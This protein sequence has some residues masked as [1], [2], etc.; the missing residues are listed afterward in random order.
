MQQLMQAESMQAVHFQ[1]RDFM[2]ACVQCSRESCSSWKVTS[3]FFF[4][5]WKLNWKWCL[6]K[7]FCCWKVIVTFKGR[8]EELKTVTFLWLR[9]WVF[10]FWQYSTSSR[11]LISSEKLEMQFVGWEW[12]QDSSYRPVLRGILHSSLMQSKQQNFPTYC[13]CTEFTWT[14]SHHER[15]S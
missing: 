6:R 12:K 3:H 2:H 8:R 4:P 9:V 10:L 1:S 5:A 14:C 7:K 11:S 13:P 15:L